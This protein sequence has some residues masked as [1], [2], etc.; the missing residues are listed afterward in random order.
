[1]KISPILC[2]TSSSRDVLSIG[3]AKTDAVNFHI[4]T[5]PECL[6]QD[7]EERTAQPHICSNIARVANGFNR[8][9]PSL[10][11]TRGEMGNS[12]ACEG[13]TSSEINQT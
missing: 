4:P 2:I 10:T 12:T 11:G 8:T 6:D 13:R 1:M 3:N 5:V 9:T 7:S